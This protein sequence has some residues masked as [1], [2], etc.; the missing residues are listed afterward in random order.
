MFLGTCE[1]WMTKMP[2]EK[3]STQIWLNRSERR[4]L[5]AFADNIFQ[6]V[7]YQFLLS[8]NRVTICQLYLNPLLSLCSWH[9]HG[10]VSGQSN[11]RDLFCYIYFM[12]LHVLFSW[13]LKHHKKVGFEW[14]SAIINMSIKSIIRRKKECYPILK[15]S[16]WNERKK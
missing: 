11:Q 16:S 9:F 7:F 15:K 3:P 2:Q 12:F 6:C 8:C 14:I 1:W 13:L 4:I 10:G 5:P